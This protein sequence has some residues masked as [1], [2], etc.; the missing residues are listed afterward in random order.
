LWRVESIAA[1]TATST[2][3]P[4]RLATTQLNLTNQ[5]PSPPSIKAIELPLILKRLPSML[6]PLTED[7]STIEVLHTLANLSVNVDSAGRIHFAETYIAIIQFG[8]C[9]QQHEQRRVPTLPSFCSR[10]EKKMRGGGS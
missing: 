9:Q 4:H 5:P 8:E 6:C 2:N 7:S 1:A 10:G 3:N